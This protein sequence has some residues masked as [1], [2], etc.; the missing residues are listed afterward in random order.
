MEK[1]RR[2]S[3]QES[4]SPWNE[5]YPPDVLSLVYVHGRRGFDWALN[6]EIKIYLS[7]QKKKENEGILETHELGVPSH[8]VTSRER[9]WTVSFIRLFIFLL[10]SLV[11]D[12]KE[13]VDSIR[14]TFRVA[15]KLIRFGIGTD[16]IE[17]RRSC[18]TSSGP[19]PSIE[20]EEKQENRKKK[21]KI[22][23]ADFNFETNRESFD[24]ETTSDLSERRSQ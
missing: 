12:R 15:G 7:R 5:L 6:I 20:Q 24:R 19:L 22:M 21:R 14:A 1:Y 13:V 4:P 9:E 3:I 2:E 17:S 10:L 8:G 16:E 23:S 18:L 11:S